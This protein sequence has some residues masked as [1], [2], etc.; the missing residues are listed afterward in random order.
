MD[1]KPALY[2]P[3][4]AIHELAKD[5]VEDFPVTATAA[6]LVDDASLV[7]WR[8]SYRCRLIYAVHYRGMHFSP[9]RALRMC[10]RPR[11]ARAYF[12]Y[13]CPWCS[14]PLKKCIS[15]QGPGVGISLKLIGP[16]RPPP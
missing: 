8:I 12:S 1:Q 16:L 13:A 3:V 9:V 11:L 14:T 2:V 7:D 15:R 10:S 4:Q 6:A 5:E